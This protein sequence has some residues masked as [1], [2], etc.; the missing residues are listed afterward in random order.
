VAAIE[1]SGSI[2]S[3]EQNQ[4][5]LLAVSRLSKKAAVPAVLNDLGETHRPNSVLLA[6]MDLDPKL[7]R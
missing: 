1:R 5:S 4:M 7:L 6:N 2:Y 3:E